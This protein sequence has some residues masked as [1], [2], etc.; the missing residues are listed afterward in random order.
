[1]RAGKV[2]CRS[3]TVC[4]DCDKD[5]DEQNEGRKPHGTFILRVLKYDY[6]QSCASSFQ[7]LGDKAVNTNRKLALV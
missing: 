7:L 1:M 3:S 5:V 4:I 6:I 2:S